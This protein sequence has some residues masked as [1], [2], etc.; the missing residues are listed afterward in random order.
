METVDALELELELSSSPPPPPP[1]QA[2]TG[3]HTSMGGAAATGAEWRPT[4]A[5]EPAGEGAPATL[6]VGSGRRR[7]MTGGGDNAAG[8]TGISSAWEAAGSKPL[9]LDGAVNPVER[10]S[11][12]A[13]RARTEAGMPLDGLS[14]NLEI[15]GGGHDSDVVEETAASE[16]ADK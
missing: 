12:A 14:A 4:D 1:P 7:R 11:M 15:S 13:A 9:R 6:G 2:A 8:A 5:T 16:A 10:A 3:M